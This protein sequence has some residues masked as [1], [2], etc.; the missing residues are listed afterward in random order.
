MII[1]MNIMIS[2]YYDFILMNIMISTVVY[3][4]SICMLTVMSIQST[5]RPPK[6]VLWNVISNQPRLTYTRAT[7]R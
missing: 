4:R 3:V 1:L 2:E 5:L 6:L 7:V